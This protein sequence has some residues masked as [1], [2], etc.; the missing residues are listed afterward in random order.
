MHQIVEAQNNILGDYNKKFSDFENRIA[1]EM[2]TKFE[3][4]IPM[5]DSLKN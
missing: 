3:K 4:L 2:H 1:L 5:I